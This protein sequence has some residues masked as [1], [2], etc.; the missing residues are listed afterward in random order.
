MFIIHYFAV[1]VSSNDKYV[2]TQSETTHHPVS[3]SIAIISSTAIRTSEYK[4]LKFTILTMVFINIIFQSGIN[5]RSHSSSSMFVSCVYQCWSMHMWSSCFSIC[6]HFISRSVCY[7]VLVTLNCYYIQSFSV[8]VALPVSVLMSSLLT[9]LISVVVTIYLMRQKHKQVCKQQQQ[10]TS[11][12][13]IVVYDTPVFQLHN[14][15]LEMN[16]NK[17]YGQIDFK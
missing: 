2:T 6:R 17:A 10:Q 12:E 9:G 13:P 8:T 11:N 3:T 7:T 16:T 4:C 15:E 1:V 5:A 14:T